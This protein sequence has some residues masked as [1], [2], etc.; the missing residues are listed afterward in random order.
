MKHGIPEDE[1]MAWLIASC[2]ESGVPLYVDDIEV[3]HRVA[4]LVKR[5]EIEPKSRPRRSGAPV[6]LS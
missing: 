1:F 5:T 3:L 2:D 4:R 6:E